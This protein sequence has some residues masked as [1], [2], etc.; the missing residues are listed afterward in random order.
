MNWSGYITLASVATIKFMFS[1]IP[2]PAL[3]LSFFETGCSIFLGGSVSAAFFY[4]SSEF[5]MNRAADKRRKAR[6]DS[7]ELGAGIGQKKNFSRMNKWVVKLKLRLGKLGV[8]FWAPFFLSVPI[9]SIVVAK[10]YGKHSNAFLLIL[11]G[12][13][14]NSCITTFLVYVFF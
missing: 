3:G 2:G 7:Q 1:A 14:L 5:F 10:F 6:L 11:I 13:L 12:M 9:G 4:F 8:C